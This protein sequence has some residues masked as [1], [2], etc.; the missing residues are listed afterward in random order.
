MCRSVLLI[1]YSRQIRDGGSSSAPLLG[2]LCGSALP[3]AIFSSGNRLWLRFRP[4]RLPLRG[5]DMTYTS[6]DQGT[7][8]HYPVA[9]FALILAIDV[10][11]VAGAAGAFSTRADR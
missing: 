8:H 3:D 1:F 4:S 6:S 5:Y 11:Q 10:T 2:N 7:L 9:R